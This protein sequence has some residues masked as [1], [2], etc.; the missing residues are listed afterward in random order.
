VL[1]PDG[2]VELVKVALPD[3]SS[4]VVARTVEPSEKVK[5]PVGVP[6]VPVVLLT[7]AVSETDWLKLLGLALLCTAMAVE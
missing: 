4:A 1:E 3:P 2:S 7:V 5:L 6:P